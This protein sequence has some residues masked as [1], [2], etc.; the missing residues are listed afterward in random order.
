MNRH[1]AFESFPIC[2]SGLDPES[3]I[4][5]T[6]WM[7]VFTGMTTLIALFAIVTQSLRRYDTVKKNFSKLQGIC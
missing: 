6:F 7:P 2:H 1:L 5:N 4:F 3:S